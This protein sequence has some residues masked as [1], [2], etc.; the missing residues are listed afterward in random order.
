MYSLSLSLFTTPCSELHQE[1]VLGEDLQMPVLFLSSC[2]AQALELASIFLNQLVWRSLLDNVAL[3]HHQN[4]AAWH[5]GLY[6]QR[7]SVAA[8]W[9]KTYPEAMSNYQDRGILKLLM[10]H[11]RDL[12]VGLGVDTSSRFIQYKNLVL[13]E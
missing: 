10:H 8:R 6:S 3:I 5:D 13:L 2:L 9:S 4:L 12:G 1:R 11:P 7:M